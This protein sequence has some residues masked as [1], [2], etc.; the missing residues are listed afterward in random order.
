MK[1]AKENKLCY[2]L[3]K[4]DA[5][6]KKYSEKLNTINNFAVE[7][8]MLP[9]GHFFNRFYNLLGF[10]LT[11]LVGMVRYDTMLAAKGFRQLGSDLPTGTK[12][13]LGLGFLA[14]YIA[15]SAV[16]I[17]IVWFMKLFFKRTRP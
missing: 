3:A 6:D 5:L 16:M 11:T 15:S 13:R 1:M 2:A 10:L 7:I 17:G 4:L 14:F 8:V 12:L 9:F